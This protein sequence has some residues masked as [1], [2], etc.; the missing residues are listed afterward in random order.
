M[1]KLLSIDPQLNKTLKQFVSST[2]QRLLTGGL[3][4]S[5]QTTANWMR[6]VGEINEKKFLLGKLDKPRFAYLD[7]PNDISEKGNIEM[8][9]CVSLIENTVTFGDR[10]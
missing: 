5:T 6:A 9:L 7:C 10:E 2:S 8:N 1:S 3:G 4:V